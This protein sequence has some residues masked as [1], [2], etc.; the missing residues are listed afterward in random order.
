MIHK[1]DCL[2]VLA[3][4]ADDSVDHVI[5]DPP[6]EAECHDGGG[7]VRGNSRWYRDE[8][9]PTVLTKTPPDFA[10]MSPSL[11]AAVAAEVCRVSRGWVLVFCQDQGIHPWM[12]ELDQH[13]KFRRVCIWHKTNP[14]PKF[15]GDG[16]AQGHEPFLAYWS[17]KGHSKWNAGGRSGVFAHALARRERG[18]RNHPTEKPLPLLREL[19]LCFTLPGETILDPFAGSGSTLVAAAET[20]RS[21]IGVEIS[22]KYAQRAEDRLSCARAIPS[23]ELSRVTAVN[24]RAFGVA[25]TAVSQ[26]MLDGIE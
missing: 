13:A 14:M 20:G 1:G 25:G 8:P 12:T 19:I 16:P 23:Y 11:R 18:V 21:G 24:P 10:C 17:G 22:P 5:T 7:M 9:D 15:L 2:E 3:G 6:Y 4:M 26:G